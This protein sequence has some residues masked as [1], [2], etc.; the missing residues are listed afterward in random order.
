MS[1]PRLIDLS[2]TEF[3]E[4]LAS[5]TPTPGGGSMAAY[6]VASGS[7][8]SAMAFRFTSGE[9]Y[10]AV[11]SAMSRRVEAL[12]A[13]RA[14]ALLLVDLDS[15]AYDAVTNAYKLPKATDAEKA[16]RKEAIQIGL[17]RAL[18]VPGETIVHAVAALRLCADG[19]ADINPN[20]VSDCMSGAACLS[21][22]AEA[23]A[24]NV[25]INA[26]SIADKDY[27]AAQLVASKALTEEA[28]RLL[29]SART[30]AARHLPA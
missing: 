18:E 21:S 30:A 25:R 12:D 23:A 17:T 14:R 5:R 20:L 8:L 3:G 16:A 11:E 15:E 6:L 10:A 4:R 1:A 22:A 19:M 2:L 27:A 24:L 13:I 9:K 28:Q 26:A 29:A 7:A